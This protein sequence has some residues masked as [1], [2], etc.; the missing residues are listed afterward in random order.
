MDTESR[1]RAGDRLSRSAPS[2]VAAGRRR[3]AEGSMLLYHTPSG[4]VKWRTDFQCFE[5]GR[6][7]TRAGHLRVRGRVSPRVALR[8]G[9]CLGREGTRSRVGTVRPIESVGRRPP[10]EMELPPP[11]ATVFPFRSPPPP[12]P[13]PHPRAHRL[14]TESL[15]ASAPPG[16]CIIQPNWET[17]GLSDPREGAS[18]RADRSEGARLP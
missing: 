3:V 15:G 11:T 9:M 14:R 13:H 5:K 7:L 4:Q 10:V 2:L 17:G 6:A 1:G 16:C 8:A 12:H 18:R